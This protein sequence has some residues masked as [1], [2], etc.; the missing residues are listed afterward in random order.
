MKAR[1]FSFTR[2][3]PPFGRNC[4]SAAKKK[5]SAPAPGG[6]RVEVAA[7][8]ESCTGIP[9]TS[10]QTCEQEEEVR[11]KVRDPP[12]VIGDTQGPRD[13]RAASHN[14]TP[15]FGSILQLQVVGFLPRSGL[16]SFPQK[17][18]HHRHTA[19]VPQTRQP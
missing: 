16:A 9:F 5:A 12:S 10:M 7:C 18:L 4:R 17:P 1:P 3:R 14:S 6:I 13:A 2:K 8:V 15:N 11:Q 19:E